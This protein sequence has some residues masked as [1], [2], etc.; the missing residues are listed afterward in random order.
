MIV[1]C[2]QCRAFSREKGRCG[3]GKINPH[4]KKYVREAM[5]VMGPSYICGKNEFKG[6]VI[7]ELYSELEHKKNA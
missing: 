7:Q 5:Q 2:R 6:A 3:E 1:K 4:V